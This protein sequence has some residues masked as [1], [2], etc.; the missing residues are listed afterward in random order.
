MKESVHSR[1][2]NLRR[3][4]TVSEME[5]HSKLCRENDHQLVTPRSSVSQLS[6]EAIVGFQLN[7]YGESKDA[8]GLNY[9]VNL[10]A[11][12]CMSMKFM[13]R[14]YFLSYIINTV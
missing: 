2:V 6:L 7:P 3:S 9:V 13:F 14:L 12:L 4:N 1:R 11:V 8:T 5:G 10:I